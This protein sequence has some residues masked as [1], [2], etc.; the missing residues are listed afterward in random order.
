MSLRYELTFC[1]FLCCLHEKLLVHQKH[2]HVMK[3]V[4]AC[5]INETQKIEA[6]AV[7]LFYD[8]LSAILHS[9]IRRMVSG[10]FDIFLLEY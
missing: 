8:L 4:P 7:F 3:K 10:T 1:V 5:N 2:H 6:A 9:S